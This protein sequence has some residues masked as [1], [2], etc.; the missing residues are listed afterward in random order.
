MS[1]KLA[2]AFEKEKEPGLEL[3]D[4][5]TL[6][7]DEV[8]IGVVQRPGSEP[9]IARARV[10]RLNG[11]RASG[12][13]VRREGEGEGEEEDEAILGRDCL[14]G[15]GEEDYIE[16]LKTLTVDWSKLVAFDWRRIGMEA[17]IDQLRIG[18]HQ[19]ARAM[20]RCGGDVAG[21]LSHW[22]G[23]GCSFR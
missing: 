3:A 6:P 19:S 5:S 10:L 11:G 20:P 13:Y 14:E 9:K 23:Y 18:T 1:V 8:V 12:V 7:D 4:V 22:C 17:L 2:F 16:A 21:V 15:P